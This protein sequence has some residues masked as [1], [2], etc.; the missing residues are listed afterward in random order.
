MFWMVTCCNDNYTLQFLSELES[1]IFIRLTELIKLHFKGYIEKYI[2]RIIQYIWICFGK[3][4]LKTASHRLGD[5]LK[6]MVITVAPCWQSFSP[7]GAM[8]TPIINIFVI[9]KKMPETRHL[10]IHQNSCLIYSVNSI[11]WANIGQVLDQY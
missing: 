1:I 6:T 2:G 3:N 4:C 9:L 5:V 11:H 8:A 10:I 7:W